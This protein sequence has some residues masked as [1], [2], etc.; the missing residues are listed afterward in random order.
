MNFPFVWRYVDTNSLTLPDDI[1][2]PRAFLP[3]I[4]LNIALGTYV[5]GQFMTVPVYV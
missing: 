5:G 2:N 1:G 3:W 4:N